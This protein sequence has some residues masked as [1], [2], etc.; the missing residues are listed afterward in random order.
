MRL[1]QDTSPFLIVT[2]RGEP[3]DY[4][5]VMSLFQRWKR[6]ANG[7]FQGVRLSPHTLRHTSA[8]MRRIAGMS[9]VD[10]QTFLGHSSPVM[11]RHYSAFALSR[12]ANQA[13]LR[14]SPI[15]QLA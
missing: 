5:G 9:E 6:A 15:Q 4:E 7:A 12:S 13:A 10:L 2:E 14:T 3:L 1:R 11:T 8:T